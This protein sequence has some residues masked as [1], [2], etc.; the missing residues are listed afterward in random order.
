MNFQNFTAGLPVDW[1]GVVLHEFGH[2]IG[3]EHE[4]QSPVSGCDSQFR[5]DDD[6]G[7]VPT[8]DMYGSFIEDSS[9]RYPGIYTVL[10]GPPNNWSRDVVDFNLRQLANTTDYR[11]S[12]FDKASIMMYSFAAWMF[13]NGSASGCYTSEN[14]SLSQTDQ[15]VA[16][17]TY[18]RDLNAAV[19]SSLRGVKAIELLANRKKASPEIK[20]QAQARLKSLE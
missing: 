2:A 7:Y 6:P 10:G 3:F 17:G 18:P 12:T 14:L 9:N 4:H 1:Q 16:L 5:W 20:A 15:Q 19:A 11:Y 8:K 13:K